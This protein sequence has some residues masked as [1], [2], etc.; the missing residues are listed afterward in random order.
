MFMSTK[1]VIVI[2]ATLKGKDFPS[3]S[4]PIVRNDAFRIHVIALF[5]YVN[6]EDCIVHIY[7]ERHH[8]TT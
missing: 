7:K 1:H 3:S 4:S 8:G 6:D 2:M 5:T